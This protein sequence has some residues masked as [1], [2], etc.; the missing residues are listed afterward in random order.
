MNVSTKV[1][2]DS[3]VETFHQTFDFL[4]ATGKK[5]GTAPSLRPECSLAEVAQELGVSR[6][7]V[8]KIERSALTKLRLHA[9]KLGLDAF[10]TP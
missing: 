9:Q 7:T 10:L 3:E 5:L 6:T 8:Q 1:L 2:P 4:L